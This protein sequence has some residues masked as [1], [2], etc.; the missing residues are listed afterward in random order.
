MRRHEWEGRRTGGGGGGVAGVGGEGGGGR[1]GGWAGGEGRGGRGR[2]CKAK[3]IW[4]AGHSGHFCIAC[5]GRG[6]THRHEEKKDPGPHKHKEL[7]TIACYVTEGGYTHV[8]KQTKYLFFLISS[9]YFSVGP[10]VNAEVGMSSQRLS[11]ASHDRNARCVGT[12]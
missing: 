12:R 1:G 8:Q 2:G 7:L 4:D 9:D 10:E 6:Q 5:I 3:A 11:L